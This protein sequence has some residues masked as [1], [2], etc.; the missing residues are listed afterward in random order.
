MDNVTHT[1]TGLMMARTGLG[2][3][4][5][6]AAVMMMLAANA[7]DMDVVSWFGGTL[8]YLEHHREYTHALAFAPL[9]AF[10]PFAL[11]R[12]IGRA[13]LGLAAYLGAL[14]GVLVHLLLDTTNVYG[15]RLLLPFSDRWLRLD[16]TDIVDPWILTILVLALTAPALVKL[17]S[18][19][20]GGRRQPSPKHGWAVFALLALFTY[21]CGRFVSHTRA[22]AILNSHLYGGALARRVTA[23]PTGANPL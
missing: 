22:L 19:E 4:T 21:E 17:V 6:G 3:K 13:P 5:K 15:V 18:D 10:V 8:T 14:V 11:V 9:V 7:P 1:L 16:M 23:T 20:I 2:G 12:W